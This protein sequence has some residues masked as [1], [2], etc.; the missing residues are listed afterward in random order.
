MDAP[1]LPPMNAEERAR[2]A[3]VLADY[4]AKAANESH[5]PGEEGT[6][7][8]MNL[9]GVI[10]MWNAHRLLLDAQGVPR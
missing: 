2:R 10:G 3:E 8:R 9:L 1:S 7:G 6:R 4:L 5:A